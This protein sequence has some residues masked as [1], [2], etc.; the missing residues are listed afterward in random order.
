M[1]KRLLSTSTKYF[2]MDQATFAGPNMMTKMLRKQKIQIEKHKQRL[3]N[4]QK[5]PASKSKP[6]KL[7]FQD[8]DKTKAFNLLFQQNLL[9]VLHSPSFNHHFVNSGLTITK[10]CT[11]YLEP[12]K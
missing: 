10:V 8:T 5:P 11:I 2:R 4:N 7:K 6:N 1:I 3:Q 12:T 9:L